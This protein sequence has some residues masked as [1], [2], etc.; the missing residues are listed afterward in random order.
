MLCSFDANGFFLYVQSTGPKNT[1]AL[2]TVPLLRMADQVHLF[3]M[4]KGRKQE[5]VTVAQGRQQILAHQWHIWSGEIAIFSKGNL[6][7]SKHRC[8][9]ALG[10]HSCPCHFM[11]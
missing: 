2:W 6:Q 7:L 10:T 1:R 5:E 9:I 11:E 8:L 4:P 3:H